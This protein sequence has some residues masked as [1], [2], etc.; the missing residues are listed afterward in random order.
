MN[1]GNT[2]EP[3]LVEDG[4]GKPSNDEDAE[5]NSPKGSRQK[6]N[7]SFYDKPNCVICSRLN[8][9]FSRYEFRR[10]LSTFVSTSTL[11]MSVSTDWL[12]AHVVSIKYK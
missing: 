6:V 8:R 9:A 7:R 1:D 3:M 5:A 10:T 2:K 11:H 12:H 4:A